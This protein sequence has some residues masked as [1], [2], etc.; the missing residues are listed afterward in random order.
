[1]DGED[2]EL[3]EEDGPAHGADDLIH[4]C[5]DVPGPCTHGV[6]AQV[7]VRVKVRVGV[8]VGVRVKAEISLVNFIL[9]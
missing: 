5:R 2:R 9:S 3:G 4:L 7:R 8:R 1:V 6:R